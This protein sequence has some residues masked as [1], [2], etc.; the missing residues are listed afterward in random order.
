ML[1]IQQVDDPTKRREVSAKSFKHWP[2]AKEVP[3][4]KYGGRNIFVVVDPTVEVKREPV[5]PV[6]PPEAQQVI[7]AATKRQAE[8]VTPAPKPKTKSTAK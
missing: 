2:D 6:V 1:T 8:G 4:G 3:G 5:K 7:D